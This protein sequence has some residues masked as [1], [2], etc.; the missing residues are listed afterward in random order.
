MRSKAL[1][2]GKYLAAGTLVERLARL[3]RN[4]LLA[5]VIAPDQFGIMAIALAVISLFEAVTEVGVAQAVIQNKNGGTPE[6][7]NVAWW[8]GAARG[9]VIAALAVPLAGPIAAFYGEPHLA[10]LLMVAPLTV[11]FTG[12]ASPRMYALQRQFEFRATLFTIQGS[13]II[14][15]AF[16]ILLGFLLQNVWALLWGAVFEAFLRFLLSF[17][18]CPIRPRFHLEAQSRKDLFQFTRG[19]AGL[20]V[21]TLLVMQADTIVLGKVVDAHHLGLYTMA[22][23]LAAFPLGIFSK[24]VRPLVVPILA[25]FQD[26]P[27]GMRRSVQSLSRLVW[28]FGL[29]LTTVMASV[30]APLLIMVYGRPEFAQAAPA[31]AIYSLFAIVYMASMVSFSVYLAIGQPELQRRF[32]V[33]RAIVVAVTLYPLAVLMGGT[34][35]ALSLLVAMIVA[36]LVQ[37][38]NLR[39]VIGLPVHSY[40]STMGAGLVVSVITAIPCLAVALFLRAPGWIEVLAGALVGAAAWALLLLRERRTIRALRATAK[41]SGTVPVTAD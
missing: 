20:S 7:L 26:D 28:L 30:S 31:F 33:V 15:T 2:G 21:L 19:M 13:G 18:L 32:T 5:R 11:I 36:M 37:L 35:A 23:A 3:G 14:A 25:H 17:I 27:A 10:S 9:L 34:G 39:T 1:R 29:P 16:T 6:F 38:F 12:L 8:F 24:V 41:S 22:I 40:L 4:M